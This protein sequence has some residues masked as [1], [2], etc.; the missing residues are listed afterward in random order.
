MKL[1]QTKKFLHKKGNSIMKSQPTKRKKTLTNH[2]PDKKLT[3]EVE[4]ELI[5]LNSD[6]MVK[7]G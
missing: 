1:H 5:H 4:K 7:N 3:S 6:K 2:V